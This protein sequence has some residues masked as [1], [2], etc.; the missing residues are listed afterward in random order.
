MFA[1]AAGPIG[2]CID[3]SQDPA[4]EAAPP[5]W[6]GY[7]GTPDAD[8]TAAKAQSLG[9]TRLA[10]PIDIPD[11]GRMYVLADPQGAVFSLHQSAKPSGE[12]AAAALGRVAWCEL[13]AANHAEV[14]PFYAELFGWV[15]SAEIDMGPVG[16]YRIFNSGG[17]SALGGMMNGQ[18]GWGPPRWRYYASV[19]DIRA[20]VERARTRGA[21]ITMEPHEVPGG[22]VIAVFLD[23][24]G[25]EFGLVQNAV[26][27]SE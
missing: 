25:I 20:S 17:A 12:P 4:G 22:D 8:S 24:E 27:A 26:A 7:V 16:K 10:G 19:V 23:P 5:C 14:W 18:P 6:M 9:A 3:L 21:T 13:L 15:T 2:G 11:V 1:N